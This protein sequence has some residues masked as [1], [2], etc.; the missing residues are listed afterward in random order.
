MVHLS[1]T[2]FF[3]ALRRLSPYSYKRRN[4]DSKL[5]QTILVGSQ[6][7]EGVLRAEEVSEG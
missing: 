1:E 5:T 4:L 2:A 3:V 7:L 6:S